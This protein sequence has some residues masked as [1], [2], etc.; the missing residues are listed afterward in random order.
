MHRAKELQGD[1]RPSLWRDF[2]SPSEADGIRVTDHEK[3]VVPVRMQDQ[4]AGPYTAQRQ[5]Q[6]LRRVEGVVAVAPVEGHYCRRTVVV[7][8][9]R[10]RATY[11][12]AMALHMQIVVAGA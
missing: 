8:P 6:R 5:G 7:D 12:D 4:I 1:L 10:A 11:D 9:V 3:K 2:P